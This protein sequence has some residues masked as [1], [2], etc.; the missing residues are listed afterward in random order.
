MSAIAISCLQIPNTPIKFAITAVVV[1]AFMI[2]VT[3]LETFCDPLNRNKLRDFGTAPGETIFPAW[4][5]MFAA[6]YVVYMLAA[7]GTAFKCKG[8]T[9]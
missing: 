5:A 4:L 9:Q 7:A 3:K 2:S 8:G 6:G 1:A